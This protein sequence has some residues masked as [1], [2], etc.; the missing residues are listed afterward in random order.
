MKPLKL[1]FSAFG[2]YTKKNVLD[3][4]DLKGRSFFLIHGPTGAG[5]TTILDAICFA[6]YGD[7]SGEKREAKMLR[8]NQAEAGEATEVDF[9]FAIGQEVYRVWRSPEQ[10]RPKKR[11]DGLTLS[12][13]DALLYKVEADKEKLLV[14]GYAK[15]TEQ[16]EQLLGF[17]SSQFRQVVLLPQGEFRQLLLANSAQRQEIME[18]LFK[19]E[20]Y[21]QIEEQLK[22]QA[23]DIEAAQME[24]RQKQLFIHEEF[25][26][27]SDAAL[28]EKIAM[29]QMESAKQKQIAEQLQGKQQTAQ[30]ILSDGRLLEERFLAAEAGEKEIAACTELLT[31]VE[32]A[33]IELASAEKAASLGD[34][35]KQMLAAKEEEKAM[36]DNLLLCKKRQEQLAQQHDEAALAAKL[37][38]EKEAERKAADTLLMQLE[39]YM[40]Q[41]I[42]LIDAAKKEKEQESAYKLCL[43]EKEK[44]EK[45]FALVQQLLQKTQETQQEL[46]KQASLKDACRLQLAEIERQQS[47]YD[48]NDKLE[49]SLLAASREY[50]EKLESFKKAETAY[51]K[52]QIE[53]Q[54]LQHLFMQGQAAVLAAGLKDGDACPVCGALAHPSLAVSSEILPTENEIKQ[55]QEELKAADV[56]RQ[57]C[58]HANEQAKANKNTIEKQLA[59]Q[60]NAISELPSKESLADHSKKIQQEYQLAKTAEEKLLQLAKDIDAL[61]VKEKEQGE[62]IARLSLEMQALHGKWQAALAVENE[63]K[64]ALPE[65]YRQQEALALA[66]QAAVL[67]Q[68]QLYD[69]FNEAQDHLQKIKEAL[70]AVEAQYKSVNESLEQS[71][72]RLELAEKEFAKRC[73]AAGF[74]NE[75]EYAAAAK[76]PPEKRDKYKEHIKR[77]EDR[78]AAAR[79]NNIK[80]KQA[81]EGTV[82]P[83][84]LTLEQKLAEASA[85]YNDAYARWQNNEKDVE[86]AKSK[87]KQLKALAEKNEQIDKKYRTIGTLAAVAGGKNVHGMTFQR[88]VLKSLLLDV[89]DASN[90]RLK[91]MSRGQY[92][93]QST[94]ERT[95]KNAAGGLEMEVFDEYTGYA[96]PVATLSG[97]ETF[98]ASLCLALGLADVVQ[99]YAGGIHLDTILVDEGFGTLDPEALDMALKALLELQKGGRL[100]GIISHVPELRERIDARL[101]VTKDRQGSSAKFCVG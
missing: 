76:W 46:L 26:V 57:A 97:G 81:I 44:L 93:L 91:I 58:Q 79:E 75:A 62:T 19:T 68:K 35:E 16:I 55:L 78:Y 9:T 73:Q 13:A 67:K 64:A 70:A 69:A 56:R 101:E 2:P 77:F 11:G 28:D 34:L 83:E 31:K 60:K 36:A 61:Q 14:Q 42:E 84:L 25:E 71:H 100:V 21:R 53:L 47:L 54:R 3:F 48:E 32:T 94:D 65:Q 49:L 66:E 89:I 7:A 63:R 80:T 51:E 4:D 50:M 29:H 17:K 33:R 74:A 39:T 85:E 12:P 96:R 43:E 30:K 72:R 22:M 8:S 92:R 1:S 38:A 95:R 5:K 90:M 15:V 86:H 59:D 18:T 24:Y 6:L 98:L 20:F 99:S 52:C 10:M 87:A 41:S 23:K 27:D 82:R 40:V 45:E 37:Q 88:F